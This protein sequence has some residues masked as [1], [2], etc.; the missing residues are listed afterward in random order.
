MKKIDLH[1]HTISTVSDVDFEFSLNTLKEY[2]NQKSIDAIA[3]VNHNMFDIN[4]YYLISENLERV[5]VF[6]GIEINIGSNRGHLLVIAEGKNVEE[7]AIKCTEVESLITT[8]EDSITMEEFKEIFGDLS[9]YLLIPHYDK[10]PRVDRNIIKALEKEIFCGEVYSPKKFIYCVKDD[11]M[12]CPVYFSDFRARA[13]IETFPG[14]QTYVDVEEINIKSLKK[15]FMDKQKVRLT[16]DEGNSMFEAFPGFMISTGLN[17]IMGE[18]SSGKSYT[19]DRV[20]ENNDN[21]KYIRQFQLLERGSESVEERNFTKVIANKRNDAENYYFEPFKKVVEEVKNVS[22]EDDEKDV[23]SYIK[24]LIRHAKESER[25]DLFA[26]CKLY[27]ENKYQHNDLNNLKGLIDSVENL[28]ESKQYQ[29]LILSVIS[30]EKLV[31]LY[32]TLIDRYTVE[33]EKEQ[34]KKWVDGVVLSIKRKLQSKSAATQVEEVDF[35]TVQ[36]NRRKVELFEKIVRVIQ[37]PY[38]IEKQDLEGFVI[39]VSTEKFAGPGDMQKLSKT[40][41]KFSDAYKEYINPYKFLQ[42]LE[43]ISELQAGDYYKYFVQ[44]KYE[45]LNRYGYKVSG[46][47]RAEF[48]LL[49]QIYDARQHDMLMIDEPESSF[50]NLFL[51]DKVNHL[52]KEIS[53]EMPVIVVTHNNTIGA[54]IKP[55]YLIYTMRNCLDENNVRYEVYTGHPSS[56][57]LV[58]KDG[59]EIPNIRATLDCLEAGEEAYKERQRDY[60]ILRD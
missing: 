26:K 50:D 10:T 56:R 32:H 12:L 2:V 39:K 57:F 58:S 3:V 55:D 33:Y 37:Q 43:E 59:K 23:E 34:K 29:E 30:R 45:I 21:V 38:T 51:R 48:N 4:Q 14:R 18:R 44:V 27:S 22:L 25:A 15:A 5:V 40:K 36:L 11:N 60:E 47:E 54:S 13:G 31:E 16:K 41:A 52:I 49:Q 17:V 20:F 8:P 6:P 53:C 9:E 19:L 35:Y 24:S 7:F 46:G 28:L 42:C 1:V